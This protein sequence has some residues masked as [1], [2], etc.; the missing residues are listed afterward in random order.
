MT[1]PAPAVL[2]PDEV[3]VG[4][5]NGPGLWIAPQGTEAPDSTS[6]D[7]E[8]PWLSGGYLSD[9]GPTVGQSTDSTD[10][11]PWQS[12]VPL[13]SVITSR[14][15]TMQFIMWQLN[16]ITLGLYFDTDPPTPGAD[17]S[18]DMEI[19]SDSPQHLYALAIDAR[20]GDRV[21][22]FS[23]TRASLSDAG[24]MAINAGAAVPL[25]VTL[26]ALDDA[27][28]LGRIQLGGAG[29]AD[30]SYRVRTRGRGKAAAAVK[31]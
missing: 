28:V 11:V 25:D 17:G 30:E 5:A 7:F 24:D 29:A 1:T 19:R 2:D 15:I 8:D 13:R 12:R 26:A 22:R 31:E 6:D 21:F 18:I 10:L 14:S 3:Q 27:G 9:D 16:A 20:D 4:T 23:F